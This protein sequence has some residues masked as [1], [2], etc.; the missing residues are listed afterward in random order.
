MFSGDYSYG[1]YLYGYPL[2]QT[3]ASF[4][5]LYRH[6]YVNFAIAY[7]L[8]AGCAVFSWWVVEKRALALRKFLKPRAKS[9]DL[10]AVAAAAPLSVEAEMQ[11]G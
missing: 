8:A 5:G 4:G 6:A 7:A 11:Q 9:G 10:S 3:V 2:Q 1:L